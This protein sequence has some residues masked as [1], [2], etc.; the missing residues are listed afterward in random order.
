[1][2]QSHRW[3][4]HRLG[5]LDQVALDTGDDLSHLREL[6]QKL[7]V[8]LSCPT[9]GLEIDTRT[10]SLL[11]TDNDGRVRAPEIL[12]AL[13]WCRPRLRSLGELIP[14]ADGL[15]LSSIDDQKPEGR[16][17]LAAAR[18]VL[19][20]L[21]KSGTT[22]TAAE[23]ADLSQIYAGTKLNGDGVVTEGSTDDPELQQALRDAV[24]TVGGVPDRSG[25]LGIDRPRLEQLFA[26]LSAYAAWARK[27]QDPQLLPFAEGTQ[28]RHAAASD[29]ETKAADYFQRC[30]LA[31]F[32]ARSVQ[33]VNAS[34]AE[35]GALASKDLSEAKELS[36]LPLAR[37]EAN[38][39]L[40][41]LE[42]VNPAF[43]ARAAA[44]A[45]LTGKSELRES[46]WLELR[47]KLSRYAAHQK[48]KQGALVEKLGLARVEA[49]LASEV[50]E[51]LSK[52]IAEDEALAA[53]SNAMADVARLVHYKR[54]LHTLLR[55][56]VNFADF[57]DPSR[58][59]VFQAGTLYL[60]SRSCELCIRVDD[61]A[62]HAVL[63]SL[64]HMYVAYCECR[65]PSG[66]AMK[67]AACFTQGDA[68]F[69]MVGRNGV[70]YDRRGR[71]W[72]ATIVKLIDNPVSMRQAFF[73][74]YKKFMRLVEEQA[75]RFAA[76]REKESDARIAATAE[77]KVAPP[78]TQTDVGKMVGIIAALG[79]GVGAVGTV[80]GAL[81]SG[82]F[83]L[84]PWW[85]KLVALAGIVLAISGPS[86][87]LAFLKLRTRTLG[88]LLDANGW[89][90]N[91]RVKVNLPLGVSLT[92][93]KALPQG[94]RWTMDDP[95][96]DKKAKRRRQIIVALLV[97]IVA[98]AFGWWL[99][100]DKR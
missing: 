92:E 74:P 4:F 76:A 85:A 66:E 32:D 39:P 30:R 44:L 63:G 69:L 61:P 86:M 21:G 88:P 75:L 54:D 98:A 78:P 52:L 51:R 95:F 80:F 68:D 70:F 81:V 49:L 67:V 96:E 53:E 90:V 73:S 83:A 9:R 60:D 31:A 72:D 50:K 42:G 29:L 20:K 38:R 89:A 12:A 18:R 13:E 79:V 1:M 94:S 64:S 48:E 10:L 27:G 100:A 26:E 93:A 77:G 84:Q 97:A 33:L 47:E 37:A 58:S 59:A 71:D 28:A 40:P 99:H 82:F 6:D 23:V 25:P 2:D 45:R 55:N 35:L 34:D 43:A 87:M 62:A 46:E 8:A 41:L 91:G 14:A 15:D 24:A 7:W 5:G 65:R 11:D 3:T 22:L 36:A 17:V 16:A 57:Y 56:F 19:G